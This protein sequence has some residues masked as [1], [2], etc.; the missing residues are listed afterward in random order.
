MIHVYVLKA[1]NHW[2]FHV[3]MTNDLSKRL[4]EHN[5]GRTKSTKGYAPWLLFFYEIYEDRVAARKREK[6]LKSGIGK[7]F[8][9]QLWEEKNPSS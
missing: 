2:R 3:G 6:Y 7:E 4:E 5:I 1:K 9:K 8:I